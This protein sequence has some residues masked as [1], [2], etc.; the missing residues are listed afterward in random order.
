MPTDKRRIMISIDDDTFS[1]LALD[2]RQ[3]GAGEVTALLEHLAE[4]I[5]RATAELQKILTPEDW[6]YLA[7]VLNGTGADLGGGP[8]WPRHTIAL[9]V[10]QVEDSHS[11]DGVGTKWYPAEDSDAR[12]R[13][14]AR[15]LRGLSETHA[16]AIAAAV[17][18]FWSRPDVARDTAWWTMAARTATELE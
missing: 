18:Y 12:V 8:G 10:A 5:G 7:D 9:L 2:P 13:A 14:L 11:L 6:W 1:S 4:L 16:E 15:R 17:R 3:A